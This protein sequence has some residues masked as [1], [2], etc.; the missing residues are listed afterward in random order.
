MDPDS[1]HEHFFKIYGIFLTKQNFQTIFLS[2]FSLIFT[3]KLGEPFRYQEIFII[4]L[5]LTVQIWILKVKSFL[6]F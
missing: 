1:G 4:S 3:L 2:F 6:Q 5:F